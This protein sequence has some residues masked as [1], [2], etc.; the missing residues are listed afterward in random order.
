MFDI[1]SNSGTPIVSTA[2]NGIE[3]DVIS[4]ALEQSNVDLAEEFT[5]LNC[6]TKRISS[7]LESNNNKR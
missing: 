4:G 6:S 2:G 3:A 7:I 5:K 1:T